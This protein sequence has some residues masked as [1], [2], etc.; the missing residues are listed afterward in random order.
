MSVIDIKQIV[1]TVQIVNA[2][3]QYDPDKKIQNKVI[4]D[5]TFRLSRMESIMDFKD[6]KNAL[7]DDPIQVKMSFDYKTNTEIYN[8]INGR[9]RIARAILENIKELPVNIII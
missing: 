7:I 2:I 6:F 4:S 8:I 9:H 3:L 1:L 5:G